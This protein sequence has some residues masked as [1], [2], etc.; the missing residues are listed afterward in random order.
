MSDQ[1][2]WRVDQRTTV[3]NPLTNALRELIDRV[4]SMEDSLSKRNIHTQDQREKMFE[5]SNFDVSKVPSLT[6]YFKRPNEVPLGVKKK[7]LDMLEAIQTTCRRRTT[8]MSRPIPRYMCSECH[9]VGDSSEIIDGKNPFDTEQAI[10]GCP[11]CSAINSEV[12]ICDIN[13]CNSE[14]TCGTPVDDD[15]VYVS[16]CGKHFN[17][18]QPTKGQQ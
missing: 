7:L 10:T 2:D 15:R 5:T 17:N 3:M 4:E 14:A 13:T 6:E 16:V 11:E 9:W 1:T 12:R 8:V 18:L